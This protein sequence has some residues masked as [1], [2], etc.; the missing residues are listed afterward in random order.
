MHLITNGLRSSIKRKIY[1][2]Q[3]VV[4]VRTHRLQEIMRKIKVKGS[5]T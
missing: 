5:H 4:P 1:K 2:S 3:I